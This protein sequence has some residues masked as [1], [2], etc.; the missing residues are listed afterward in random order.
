LDG[1]IGFRELT[2]GKLQYPL[3]NIKVPQTSLWPESQLRRLPGEIKIRYTKGVKGISGFVG[4][5]LAR[6][7]DSKD[8]DVNVLRPLERAGMNGIKFNR[9]KETAVQ[10]H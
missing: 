5:V 8:H 4:D 10:E 6:G 1:G 9:S 2:S 3:G 7:V